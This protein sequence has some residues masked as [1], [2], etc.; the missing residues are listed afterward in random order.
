MKNLLK[1]AAAKSGVETSPEKKKDSGFA[2]SIAA[3]ADMAKKDKSSDNLQEKAKQTVSRTIN[4][5]L[6]HALDSFKGDKE[7]LSSTIRPVFDAIL[8]RTLEAMTSAMSAEEDVYRDKLKSQSTLFETRL[9]TMRRAS[10]VQL[11]NRDIELTAKHERA[12]TALKRDILEGGNGSSPRL[13]A[14]FQP[15]PPSDASSHRISSRL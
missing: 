2:S 9:E 15:E 10:Q 13:A 14:R 4:D 1:A 8:H 3:L 12:M 11:K 5:G 6:A 7:A